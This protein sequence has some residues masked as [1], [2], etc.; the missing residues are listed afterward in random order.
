MFTLELSNY[1]S[2]KAKATNHE[3]SFNVNEPILGQLI[4]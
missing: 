2:F 4:A 1:F 3:L